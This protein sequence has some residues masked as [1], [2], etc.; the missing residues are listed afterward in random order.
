MRVVANAAAGHSE[1]AEG[2]RE[3]SY[4]FGQHQHPHSE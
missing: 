3:R 2:K 1:K 4:S